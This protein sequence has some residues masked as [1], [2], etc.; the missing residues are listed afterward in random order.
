[1]KVAAITIA[2]FLTVRAMT[3][4]A[5]P[6]PLPATDS[7]TNSTST[8]A[9]VPS[10]EKGFEYE[11]EYR[12]R[13]AFDAYSEALR[14]RPEDTEAQ[15][16]RIR[17]ST[18][19]RALIHYEKYIEFA[20]RLAEQADFQSAIRR[21]NEAMAVKPSYLVNSDRV[22]GLHALLMAQNKPV[23]VAFKSDRKTWVS[24]FGFRAP[25]KFEA[26]IIKMLP[27]DYTAVGRRH[28]FQ[29]VDTPLQ[30][31]GGVNPPVISIVCS[32][33]VQSP[34]PA[35]DEKADRM[36]QEREYLVGIARFRAKNAKMQAELQEE[37]QRLTAPW[38]PPVVLDDPVQL[39]KRAKF[40]ELL[41][42]AQKLS[43]RA[44]FQGAIRFFNQALAS[45]PKKEYFKNEAEFLELQATLMAQNEPVDV[46]INSDGK[47]DV[48]VMHFLPPSRDKRK[49]LRL[50]PGDYVLLG[51]RKGYRDVT[52][53][54]EI[55]NG[56]PPPVFTVVC[57][58]PSEEGKAKP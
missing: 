44:D 33:S 29:N 58:I 23:E 9:H 34:G 31:R 39:A 3:Q 48:S 38:E 19:I 56:A 57:D 5:S 43:N 55:R 50:M 41:M 42:T 16:G 36:A 6:G 32:T 45:Q 20:E 7:A 4:P 14:I 37:I 15:L 17:V 26:V 8:T 10:L 27:G 24:I 30:I 13:E 40:V 11:R 12:W 22:Q 53:L 49:A 52:I 47:T 21:F 18:V 2:L 25:E 46:V 28:G 54:A 35:L 1:M 51:T